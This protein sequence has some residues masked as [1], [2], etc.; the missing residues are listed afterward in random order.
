MANILANSTK[1]YRKATTVLFGPQGSISAEKA[2]EIRQFIQNTDSLDFLSK[3]IAELPDLWTVIVDARPDLEKISGQRQLH[4]L[5]RFFR[6]ELPLPFGEHVNNL[7]LSPL[8]VVF[9]VVEFWKLTHGVNYPSSAG[10]QFQDVQG[11]CI[12]FLTAAAVSCSGSE[13][14]FQTLASKAIRL[15]LCIG[16]TVDLDSTNTSRS[17]GD[18]RAVAVRWKSAVQFE[19]LNNTI[20]SYSGAYISVV[21]EE[22]TATITIPARHLTA[23]TSQLSDLRIPSMLL[24]TH[25]RF[26]HQDHA[27]ALLAL[28]KLCQRDERFRLPEINTAYH[29]LRSN[30]DGKLCQQNAPHDIALESILTRQSRWDLVFEASASTAKKMGNGL[31]Y[32][33]VGEKVIVPRL[34]DGVVP[35]G[36]QTNGSLS[37]GA[38]PNVSS[39]STP[40]TPRTADNYPPSAVEQYIRHRILNHADEFPENA[41]AIIGMACRYPEADSVEEFWDLINEGKCVVRELPENRFR[42]SELAREPR[43]PFWGGYVRQVDSFDHRFFGISGRE[44]KSMDPQQ[45]LC[46]QVAYEAMESSGY[47][48]IRSDKLER[49]V[50]CYIGVANDDYVANVA[51]HPVNAFSA[52]GTLRAFIGGRISHFFG[53]TGPSMTVDTAC[54]ASAVAIHTAC[55]ALQTGDCSMA[56]AGG[57]CAM[58]SS[59]MTQNLQGAG[60]LSPTGASKAF[61]ASADGYCRGEGAGLVVLRPLQ[62]AMSAGDH[63][64]GVITASTMNQGSNDSPIVVPDAKAQHSLYTKILASSRTTPSEVTYIEAHGTGTQVGDPIEFK[65]IRETFGGHHRIEDIFVGSVK[66]NIGH[67][68]ASSGIAALLKTILMMQKKSIPKQANFVRLNPN[69]EPLGK[70]HVL[71]P[72][73][74]KDWNSAKRIAVVNNYGASGNNAAIVLREASIV[75]PTLHS[76]PTTPSHFPI[77]ITGKSADAVR[78]Y[79]GSL[80]TCLGRINYKNDFADVA[81]NLATKQ[82]RNFESSLVITT[83][84]VEDFRAQ[85]EQ[86]AS[87]TELLHSA[88][89]QKPFTVLCFGGQDGLIAHISKGLYD[90]SLLLQHYLADCDSICLNQL[91]LPSLFPTI[92]ETGPIDDIVTLHCV[93][94]SIQYACAKAWIDSG[95]EVNTMIGHSFGQLTA[96]C[97]AE[98]LTLTD[99]LRLV[100]ERAKLV[101]EHC[102]SQKGLM[103]AVDGT[104]IESF[105][106]RIQRQYPGLV[107]EIACYNGPRSFVIAGDEPSIQIVEEAAAACSPTPIRSIRLT[108]SHAF[109]SKLLDDVIPSLFETAGKLNFKPPKITIE[110]CSIDDDWSEISAEKIVRHTRLA[111]HFEAAVKR[112]DDKVN[113]AVLW[114]EAGSGSP[115]IPMVKKV[116]SLK[117]VNERHMCIPTSFRTSDAE[118]NLAEATCLLWSKGVRVQFWPFHGSHEGFY[119]WIN[120]PPYQF[121][122]TSHWLEYKPTARTCGNLETMSAGVADPPLV[123]LLPKQSTQGDILFEIN[124]DHKIYQLGTQGHAVVGQT[125]CPSSLHI[126]FLL[127]AVRM[128][129]IDATTLIPRISNLTMSSPLVLCPAGRVLLRLENEP[130]KQWSWNFT[131][132]SDDEKIASSSRVSHATGCITLLGPQTVPE[133]INYILPL[134]NLILQ[135]CDDIENSSQSF[136]FKG[137][138]VYQAMHPAVT[139]TEF[140]QGINSIYTQN[141]E[142]V[143]HVILPPSRAPDMGSGFCDQVLTDNF[144]QVSGVLANCFSDREDSE[145]CINGFIG[146]IIFTQNFVGAGRKKQSWTVYCKMEK[147]SPKRLRCNTYVFDPQSGDLVVAV[148][149]TEFQKVS[150]KS[151]KKTLSRL[152]SPASMRREHETE[153]KASVGEE[154]PRT[155]GILRP[156]TSEQQIGSGS[157]HTEPPPVAA[158]LHRAKLLIGEILQIPLQ[159]VLPGSTLEDLGIDSLLITEIYAELA[160]LQIPI[161]LSDLQ[162][163]KSVQELADLMSGHSTLP[164]SIAAQQVGSPPSGQ[165]EIQT[166]A[167]SEKDGVTLLADIHYPN[168]RR[169][170]PSRLPIALLIH[171]GG[172]IL[173]TRKDIRPAQTQRLLQLGFLPVSVDYRLCPELTLKEGPMEDVCEALQ[174]ART[175]L[176][177]LNLSRSDVQADG[178][179]VVAIGWS[180][181]GHLAMTLGWTAQSL[182]IRAPEAI[183]AFYCPTDYED[184]FWYQPNLPFHQ[185]PIPSLDLSDVIHDTPLAGYSIPASL[186]ALGGWMTLDDPRSRLIL[187]M[188]WEGQTVPILLNG[189]KHSSFRDLKGTRKGSKPTAKQI[190]SISPSAQIAAGRYR[191]PT[192]IIHGTL[193]DLVP[194]QQSQR[195]YEALCEKGVPTKL[196]ILQDA[197]HLFDTYQ[198]FGRKQEVVLA[199]EDGFQFLQSHLP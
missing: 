98:S 18:T 66:D 58:T 159:E 178:D 132:F 86:V 59:T 172:H 23:F 45:R 193:D 51:S 184:A 108:N 32:I 134:K 48:G 142:A 179:R 143:A 131:I 64:L 100:S 75:Y 101:K 29:S 118:M 76:V 190:Q 116:L 20:A 54:S 156:S 9:Q 71:I 149:S 125:L 176:P 117:P 38:T 37:N 164:E 39:E 50:G 148:L 31:N 81:Y 154:E 114:I 123:H 104:D 80:I 197:P 128:L 73:Q 199:I 88:T 43:G 138:T 69:I 187:H 7:I 8:T 165:A 145:M 22:K 188:N 87:G 13:K 161:A 68:E 107:A 182:N 82:N 42:P 110:A 92:F 40:Q 72:T 90:S 96:L 119:N 74:S 167:Y 6:S 91:S 33:S 62:A 30:I 195:T 139:Y 194:W 11:L 192:F 135:R 162:V 61:D 12:G 63:I 153:F 94:F 196:E 53:W 141:N 102:S 113:G 152:N 25:G 150:T 191:T 175:V 56:V 151:L 60:F 103:L 46:L 5:A 14:E 170:M 121:A 35:N 84:N 70:D 112:I 183:L 57:V 133:E 129:S 77:L 105:L 65:S 163:V 52:M 67:T 111:V 127:T 10:R 99:A 4:E 106:R 47:C 3:S 28:K 120:L 41:I 155:N 180:T 166:I 136:G 157:S 17:L 177:K 115:I 198:S 186:R 26:H 173:S 78:A 169:D 109:H 126:E 34:P 97:V 24:S 144:N 83:G 189:L 27:N 36:I 147:A 44:A 85:L 137:P 21:T 146:D 124:H 79:C 16:A 181:G 160:K 130:S 174:W 171:G 158:S 1:E 122:R 55:K 15:A 49:D 19:H 93:L 89:G 168:E 185:R 2:N 95:L 140:Y